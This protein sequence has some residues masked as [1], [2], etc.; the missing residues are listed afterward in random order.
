MSLLF[1]FFSN[2]SCQEQL[3]IQTLNRRKKPFY[4]GTLYC[5]QLLYVISFQNSISKSLCSVGSG[6]QRTIYDASKFFQVLLIFNTFETKVHIK[7]QSV[8]SLRCKYSFYLNFN[9]VLNSVWFYS[10]VFICFQGHY[11]MLDWNYSSD[12]STFP[13]Y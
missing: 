13:H 11:F 5:Y 10:L 8:L 2:V 3:T 6:F 9:Q 12:F 7:Q 4:L 1:L